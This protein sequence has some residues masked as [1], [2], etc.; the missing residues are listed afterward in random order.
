[1][2]T[3]STATHRPSHR[4]THDRVA[5][6]ILQRYNGRATRPVRGSIKPLIAKMMKAGVILY[7]VLLVVAFEDEELGACARGLGVFGAD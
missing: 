1:M 6:V 3:S 7:L 5:K 4:S 2:L